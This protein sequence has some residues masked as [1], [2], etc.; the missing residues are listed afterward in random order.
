MSV[1]VL[2]QACKVSK[3]Y[4]GKRLRTEALR[5][6]DLTI[7]AGEAVALMGPSGCGKSTLLGVLGL[8]IRPT[9]GRLLV[10]GVEVTVDERRRARWRNEMF[11]YVHQDF[12]IIDDESVERNVMIPLEYASPRIGRKERRARACEAISQV[13]LEWAVRTKASQLSGG[14]RQRVA[15]ARSLVNKPA[16]VLA[17][18]PTAALD[19]GTAQEIITLLLAVRERSASVLVGTH[20]PQVAERCDRII[21]MR[22][23]HLFG[24]DATLG[25]VDDPASVL[26]GGRAELT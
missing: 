17:D 7:A 10:S 4:G 26:I 9:S 6:V 8:M 21:R 2:L 15:I 1:S 5:E 19:S 11:G 24:G 14:E 16:L 12:A 25:G 20:D 13:G 23:G 18:E 22:D 3:V